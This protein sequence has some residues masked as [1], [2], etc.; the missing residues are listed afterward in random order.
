MLKRL[1]L[2]ILSLRFK[3]GLI[4][5]KKVSRILKLKSCSSERAWFDAGDAPDV[6]SGDGDV[7]VEVE[8]LVVDLLLGWHGDG[9]EE[10]LVAV[11]DVTVDLDDQCDLDQVPR[12]RGRKSIL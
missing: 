1:F 7:E 5:N 12:L 2:W 10:V 4:L 9:V 6:Y 8:T 3:V 11:V